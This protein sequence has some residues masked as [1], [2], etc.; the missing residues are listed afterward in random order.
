MIPQTLVFSVVSDPTGAEEGPAPLCSASHTRHGALLI[1]DGDHILPDGFFGG[2]EG[3]TE[4]TEA[5]L[6]CSV[7]PL[8]ACL[9]LS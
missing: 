9:L 2:R 7:S 1:E 6:W 4:E 5:M 8:V 3:L